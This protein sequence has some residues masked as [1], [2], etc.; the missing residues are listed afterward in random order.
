[1]AYRNLSI[2]LPEELIA[3]MALREDPLFDNLPPQM[4]EVLNMHVRG[5]LVLTA[6]LV[7]LSCAS[8]SVG[9]QPPNTSDRGYSDLVELFE[10]WREFQQPPFREGIPDYT[11]PAMAE[12]HQKLTEYQTRLAAIDSS[13]WPVAEQIDHRLVGAE[14]NGLDFDHRVLRPWARDPAFYA[15]VIQWESD[16]PLREGPTIAGAIELWRLSFPLAADELALFKARLQAIPPLLDQARGNLV[17]DA[18]DLWQL[19]I[20]SQ[21]GQSAALAD[22]AELLGEHHPELV[23]DVERAQQAVDAFVLWLEQELP[24]KTGPSGVGI[25]NYNW[26]LRHVHL[27]PYTWEDELRLM[28]RELARSVAHMKLE[29]HNNRD[30]PPLEPPDS[31]EEWQQRASAAIDEFLAFLDDEVL[32]VEDYMEP[33][34][35]VRVSG[36][37]PPERR[38]FFAQVDLR[39]PRVMRCHQIHWIDK[40]RMRHD[41]HPSPIR[42]VPLLYNIWDSRAEGLA[43]AMEE[44]MMSAGLVDDSPRS[45]ELVYIM[46]AQRAARAI[47]G[48]R[49][50]SNEWSIDKAVVFAA[51]QTPRGWFRADGNLVLF[52]QQLYLEQPGYGTSYLTGKALIESLMTERALE[53]GDAFTLKGFME[54]LFASGVIP[55]SLIRWEITGNDSWLPRLGTPFAK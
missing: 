9:A 24:R 49:V 15:M 43:T 48:L 22:L 53:L 41:P 16:T 46:V 1:M 13:G 4:M 21:Q 28:Q 7:L 23:S 6:V 26:Y 10:K 8:P 27:V 55:V 44:M 40:V 20:L 34:L 51:E 36:Y 35:R 11:A 39:D 45:R 17:G 38:H 30:L 32:T 12:Q 19:G 2:S 52:E 5:S 3:L 33:A 14:M 42:R 25:E 47:A 54:E 31:A 29:E 50:Q 18:R 37:S